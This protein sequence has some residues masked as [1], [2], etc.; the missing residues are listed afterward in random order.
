MAD[1][2]HRDTVGRAALW[3][4]GLRLLEALGLRVNDVD[5]DRH[6]II[7]RS[8]K[9]DKDRVVMLPWALEPHLRAQLIQVRSVW[10]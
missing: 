3:Q 5:F 6:A 9:S 4:C 7:V 2:G 8:G 1:G 10:G